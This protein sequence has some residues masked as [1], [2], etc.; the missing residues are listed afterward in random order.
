VTLGAGESDRLDDARHWQGVPLGADARQQAAQHPEGDRQRDHECGAAAGLAADL[1]GSAELFDDGAHHVEAHAAAGA[2]GDLVAG[3]EPWSEHDLQQGGAGRRRVCGQ[4]AAFHRRCPQR[5]LVDA[6]PVVRDLDHDGG[7]GGTGRH[8]HGRPPRLAG[9]LP[10]GDRLAAVVDRVRD[11]VPQRVGD[12]VQD[13]GVQL[14]VLS[15]QDQLDLLGLPR[16]SGQLAHELREPGDHPVYGHHR[17]PHGPVADGGQ[18]CLRVVGAGLQ[19]AGGRADLV[20]DG[21]QRGHGGKDGGGQGCVAVG[22]CL[23]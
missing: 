3:R 15:A 17:Q 14:D 1:E 11:Q 16:G 8:P 18:P 22:D 2:A 9:G 21:D 6:P 4:Q 13:P 19:L 7:P 23:A 10:D 12:G 5:L 20:A